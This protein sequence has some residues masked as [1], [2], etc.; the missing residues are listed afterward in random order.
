MNRI[1]NILPELREVFF[2]EVEALIVR[3][4][5]VGETKRES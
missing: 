2:N 3:H 5:K 4:N 1:I